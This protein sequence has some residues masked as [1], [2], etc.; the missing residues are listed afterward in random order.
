MKRKVARRSTRGKNK[1]GKVRCKA[2][3]IWGTNNCEPKECRAYRAD[4]LVWINP[5]GKPYLI[6]FTLDNPLRDVDGDDLPRNRTIRVPA[7]SASSLFRITA[8]T[9]KVKKGQRRRYTAAAEDD[10]GVPPD[11]PVVISED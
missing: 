8:S 7:Y 10:A 4:W 5:N 9:A 2:V 3:V 1:G 11:G 6:T